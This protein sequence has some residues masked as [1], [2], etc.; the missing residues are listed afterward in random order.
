M[1]WHGHIIIF[2]L[3]KKVFENCLYIILNIFNVLK[4]NNLIF[5]IKCNCYNKNNYYNKWQQSLQKWITIV[6][7]INNNYW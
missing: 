2:S 7:L 3:E 1:Q 6:T 4:L 5:D